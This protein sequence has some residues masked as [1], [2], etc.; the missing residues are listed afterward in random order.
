MIALAFAL[1]LFAAPQ[2]GET[3]TQ[4]LLSVAKALEPSGESADTI[5]QSAVT[6]CVALEEVKP[7]ADN[8]LILNQIR[9]SFRNF[10]AL[11]I[12]RERACRHTPGCV[13]DMLPA[14]F[15]SEVAQ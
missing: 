6:A 13:S 4:C 11:H 10:L 12:T 2:P 8:E 5:A 14:P 3:H 1:G 7:T 9:D 15:R